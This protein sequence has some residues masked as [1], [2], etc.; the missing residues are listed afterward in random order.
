MAPVTPVATIAPAAGPSPT[1]FPQLAAIPPQPPQRS[2]AVLPQPPTAS[3][4]S[5]QKP[6]GSDTPAATPDA[7]PQAKFQRVVVSRD[8]VKRVQKSLRARGYAPG[9]IDEKSALKLVTL[10]DSIRCMRGAPQPA[11]S[12]GNSCRA[13]V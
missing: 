9:R 2:A 12:I 7:R 8:V 10:F 1:V 6:V 3:R 4:K 11:S 5:V 13:L